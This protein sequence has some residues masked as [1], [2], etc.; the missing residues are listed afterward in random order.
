VSQ[1]PVEPAGEAEAYLEAWR[2]I[3]RLMRQGYSWSGREK[4]CAFLNLGDGTF[5]DASGISG[6][7]FADDGRALAVVDWDGDGDQDVFVTN[8]NG[9]RLRF[10]RNDVPRG[11]AVL[12]L[13]PVGTRSNRDA[14]GARVE[15]ELE[16][17]T[18]LVR[19]R[20][21]GEGYLAQSSRWL[22]FGLGGRAVSAVRVRWPDGSR[23]TFEGVTAGRFELV[24]GTGRAASRPAAS[25]GGAGLRP[26]PPPEPASPP[27]AAG[28][29]VALVA[30]VPMPSLESEEGGTL[31]R[32]FDAPA[33]DGPAAGRATFVAL[34]AS[35][36]APC[37]AELR[38]LAER[39]PELAARGLDLVALSADADEDRPA[40][41]ALLERVGWS[42]ARGF[43]TAE[44]LEVL[45]TLYGA[46]LAQET[47]LFLPAGFLVDGGGRLVALTVG[48][49]GAD[50][51]L[52]DLALLDLDLD[53]AARRSAA[54]PFPGTWRRAPEPADLAGLERRLAARGLQRAA[55]E[56][57][58]RRMQVVRSST[59][60]VRLGF[61]ETS[62]RQGRFEEAAARYREA[63]LE[64]PRSFEARAGLAVS[65][66][67][68]DRHEEAEEAYRSALEL[69][70]E[71]PRTLL[72][73]GIL[74][75]E[76]GRLEDARAQEERLRG[77][78]PAAADHLRQRIEAAEDGD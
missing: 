27:G 59:L 18:R 7:D 30:P 35:W 21:A 52:E 78:H 8:R 26:S 32:R 15:V 68:L 77:V 43:A 51:L 14:V 71:D 25:G 74:F 6:F 60:E 49:V 22:F 53:P 4:N 70:P 46:L 41:E 3:N 54:V 76:A 5:A 29:R 56:L 12:Q 40:A 66:H 55:I 73:L 67:S 61:A 28:A 20:R 65:L 31:V 62:L 45:D 72:N 42:S 44:T 13:A 36:C 10:L 58:R 63:L 69:E 11:G 75:V 47:R 1:S 23:E 34:W 33:G 48:P 37:A 57:Q 39:A 17:G 24:E 50:G 2:A 38:A 64:D 19:A 16:D 9:P